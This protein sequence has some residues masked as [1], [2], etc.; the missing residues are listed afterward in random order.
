MRTIAID[1]DDTLNN[2]GETLQ[3]A[4]FDH[5][6]ESGLSAEV[7]AEYLTRVRG[8]AR[9][10]SALLSTEFTYFKARIHQQCYRRAAARPDGVS[11][12]R[13]LKHQGWRIVICTYRDL[14]RAGA[15][16]RQWLDENNIPFDHLFM[17][18]NK[19]VF[20]RSW[21]IKHLVDD[22]P[23]NIVHGGKHGVNVYY[24]IMAK[25]QGLAAEGARGFRT[26]GEITPWIQ[27]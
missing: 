14:R 21:Q 12:V 16:T 7:F 6:E 5:D 8:Q 10:E 26:F 25:H 9:E 1:L 3:S 17:A 19:I 13:E 24:P 22:D 23:F 2:F 15:V 18:G 27:G 4:V 20:C 11:F